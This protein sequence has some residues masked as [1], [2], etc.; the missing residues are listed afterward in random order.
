MKPIVTTCLVLVSLCA[1]TSAMAINLQARGP[2]A[3]SG[4]LTRPLSS[5]ATL[6]CDDGVDYSAF[7]QNTDDRL[8]NLF[9]FGAGA[10]LSSV[11][12]T[13]FGY[14]FSG[15]YAY[16]IE[17][18]D[19]ASCTYA[20]GRN[21]LSAASAAGSAMTEVVDLC[22]SQLYY[23]GTMVVTID[24]NTCLN[25]GD[26]YPD[27]EFDD[28]LNIACPMIVQLATTAPACVHVTGEGGA[29][30]LRVG[31][32]GCATPTRHTSWGQLRSVYR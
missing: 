3:G 28:Q 14:G 30:L 26:C 15:P 8:G 13:H 7:Y 21:G 19:P 9:D 16:D 12:F 4:P 31:T 23:A 1:A 5:T 25:P 18:W 11:E 20:G 29:F 22:S 24:P 27:L 17:V 2:H 6:Y 32:N 10:T